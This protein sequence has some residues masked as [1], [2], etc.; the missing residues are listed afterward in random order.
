MEGSHSEEEDGRTVPQPAADE[1][2]V[3]RLALQGHQTDEREA[4]HKGGTGTQYDTV[5]IFLLFKIS[6]FHLIELC[7]IQYGFSNKYCLGRRHRCIGKNADQLIYLIGIFK[8]GTIDFFLIFVKKKNVNL[9]QK[10]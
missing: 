2:D 8:S 1:A 5:Q 7:E 6:I 4:S 9:A 10:R 3:Q